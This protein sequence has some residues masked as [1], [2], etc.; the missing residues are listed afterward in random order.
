MDLDKRSRCW[1]ITYYFDKDIKDNHLPLYTGEFTHAISSRENKT[2]SVFMKW[3]TMK[4]ASSI[5]NLFDE[6]DHVVLK[7]TQWTSYDEF[8][9]IPKDSEVIRDHITSNSDQGSTI[10]DS[11]HAGDHETSID[12]KNNSSITIQDIEKFRSIKRKISNLENE[13]G[14]LCKRFKPFIDTLTDIQK[15]VIDR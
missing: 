5:T 7:K 8:K 1:I 11:D 12:D 14:V 9:K 10:S 15:D 2:C 6:Y 13:L 4:T 3:K